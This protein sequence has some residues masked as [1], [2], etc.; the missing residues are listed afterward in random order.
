MAAVVIVVVI[1]WDPSPS[2]SINL[3]CN[4]RLVSLLLSM[5]CRDGTR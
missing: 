4:F 1:F 5:G 3:L 2:S